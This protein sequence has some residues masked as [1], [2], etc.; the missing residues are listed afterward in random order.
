MGDQ[1]LEKLQSNEKCL[2]VDQISFEIE[3]FLVDRILADYCDIIKWQYTQN[4]RK[5]LD[6][7]ER[8]DNAAD[9]TTHHVKWKTTAAK[10]R[11][12][13]LKYEIGNQ[14]DLRKLR[15]LK[16]IRTDIAH[17]VL[18]VNPDE[19]KKIINDHMKKELNDQDRCDAEYL[20]NMY[21]KLSTGNC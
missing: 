10:K 4:L 8:A 18:P 11:W 3:K 5:L 2:L 19:I 7:L 15:K 6:E 13:E 14:T 17:P 20:C 1:Q 16:K 9:P 12:T 21:T